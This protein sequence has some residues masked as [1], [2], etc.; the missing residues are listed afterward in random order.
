MFLGGKMI[1]FWRGA[2]WAMPVFPATLEAEIRRIM[3]QGQLGQEFS[4]TPS[5]Q[6]SQVRWLTSVIPAM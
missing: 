2:C 1:E 5:Q 6:M 3:V 4:E